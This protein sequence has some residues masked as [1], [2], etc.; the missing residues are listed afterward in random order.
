MCINGKRQCLIDWGDKVTFIK[1]PKNLI[2]KLLK[3]DMDMSKIMSDSMWAISG[4]YEQ[5]RQHEH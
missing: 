5:E 4:Y 2:E 1:V 3:W